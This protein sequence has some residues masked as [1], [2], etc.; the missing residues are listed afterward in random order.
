[1]AKTN[2]ERQAE[3]RKR[4]PSAGEKGD[5]DRRLNTWVSSQASLALARLSVHYGV[6]MREM[7]EDLII[8]TDE[9][10]LKKLDPESVEWKAYFAKKP[11]EK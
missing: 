2:A 9:R 8:R 5:G 3:Y 4:R 1:M 11:A 7:I 10:V 6:T